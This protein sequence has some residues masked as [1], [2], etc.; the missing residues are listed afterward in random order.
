[1][2]YLYQKS[3]QHFGQLAEGAESCGMEELE[4]LGA[5]DIRA[6]YRGVYFK[7]DQRTLYTIVYRTRIFTR[8]L[9]P[10]LVFDCH[11]AKYLHRTAQQIDWSRF[12]TL[13]KTFAIAANVSG[14]AIRN[15]QYAGQVLKDAIVDQFRERT[16]NRPSVD[17]RNP[18]LLLNLHIHENKARISVDLGGGSLHRRG[19]REASVEAPMQETLAAALLRFSGW[20]GSRPLY[21][22]F[23][24]S[25][26]ILCEAFMRQQRIPAAFLRRKFGLLRLPD[27]DAAVWNQVRTK[28][29]AEILPGGQAETTAPALISGSDIDPEAVKAVR[30]NRRQLPGAESVKVRRADFRELEGFTDTDIITNPPHGIRLGDAAGTAQL[31]KA[32][33]DFLKQKC[34]GSSA[35]VFYGDKSLVKQ[36]GLK[37]EWKKELKSGGLDGVFCK[38]ALY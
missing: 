32:F 23:C 15:S 17:T 35:F 34:T 31:L 6:G 27:F 10:L 9:S 3:G 18:D 30:T 14:S 25:G 33:G 8:I 20:D 36:L 37:P 19:Y 26:T 22:P 21:D 12:L 5:S 28:A 29:N 13:T 38:Y 7:A 2:D 16:G 11:S 1:M 4:E 24:G